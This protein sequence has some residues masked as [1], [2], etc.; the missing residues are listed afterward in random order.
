MS[1]CEKSTSE[2]STEEKEQLQSRIV[3]VAAENDSLKKQVLAMGSW[4]I[5]DRWHEIRHYF[6]LERLCEQEF[7]ISVQNKRLKNQILA[8]H[9]ILVK[10]FKQELMQS[11]AYLTR[12]LQQIEESKCAET[13]DDLQRFIP[14]HSLE[15]M[16]PELEDLIHCSQKNRWVSAVKTVIIG[17]DRRI[18]NC[19]ELATSILEKEEEEKLKLQNYINDLRANWTTQA[20]KRARLYLLT[21]RSGSEDERMKYFFA[22]KGI[23]RTPSLGKC[24]MSELMEEYGVE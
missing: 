10:S 15:V 7:H 17:L 23:C 20:K 4:P 11:R 12:K 9:R 6:L 16:F 22:V 24:S 3:E 8:T 18:A 2:C 5:I 19:E 14:A 13:V 21:A 1:N